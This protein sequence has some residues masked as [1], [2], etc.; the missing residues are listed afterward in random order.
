M[1]NTKLD[2]I[3]VN[4][5]DIKPYWNNPRDNSEAIEYLKKSIIKFG[6]QNPLVLDKNYVVICGHTRLEA[7]KQLGLKVLPCNIAEELTEEQV[8][9][10]RL[11]DNKVQEFSSWD[12]DK[13]QEELGNIKDIDM[14][15]FQFFLFDD[16]TGEDD[17]EESAAGTNEPVSKQKVCTCP[18]C[19]RQ[20]EL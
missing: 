19:G 11:A 7:A 8:N 6:F 17:A 3:N 12:F 5:D 10:Y 13:L 2:I 1:I 9:A 18:K 4:I 15:E 14:G 20:F 16:E